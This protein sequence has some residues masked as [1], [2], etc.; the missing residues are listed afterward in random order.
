MSITPHT[1]KIIK[2][3]PYTR[4][5]TD[6]CACTFVHTHVHISMNTDENNQCA[7]YT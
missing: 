4:I 5:Y 1:L 2:N 6:M 3:L 7:Y